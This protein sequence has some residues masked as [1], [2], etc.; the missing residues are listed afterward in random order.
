MSQEFSQLGVESFNGFVAY[1]EIQN[2]NILYSVTSEGPNSLTYLGVP[3]FQ[4]GYNSYRYE[5]GSKVYCLRSNRSSKVYIIG[6]IPDPN[7]AIVN[8]NPEPRPGEIVLNSGSANNSGFV[9]L[10]KSEDL[11]IFSGKNQNTKI[12]LTPYNI[13]FQ[14][15]DFNCFFEKSSFSFSP[16]SY[17]GFNMIR[18][19]TLLKSELGVKIY[20]GEGGIQ[21]NGETFSFY[22]IN[23]IPGKKSLALE[24]QKEINPQVDYSIYISKNSQYFNATSKGIFNYGENFSVKVGGLAGG[25]TSVGFEVTKG[26]FNINTGSGSIKFYMN[27]ALSSQFSLKISE[28]AQMYLKQSEYLVEIGSGFP[29]SIKI[30]TSSIVITSQGIGGSKNKIKLDG[31]VEITGTLLVKE[32]TKLEKNMTVTADVYSTGE[33]YAQAENTPNGGSSSAKSVGLSTHITATAVPGPAVPPTAG[34]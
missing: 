29:N 28:V 20:G 15:N 12:Q 32:K 13:K 16:D 6:Q 18:G 7:V 24:K 10:G 3:L 1:S 22:Q 26:N 5:N 27:N 21:L 19:A 9:G 2:G 14:V 8:G 34:T 11:T 33:V 17:N 25:T 31:N 30:D 4:F 23:K